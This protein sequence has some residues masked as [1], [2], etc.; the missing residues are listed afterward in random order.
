VAGFELGPERC[1]LL[2]PQIEWL[3][4]EAENLAALD[5]SSAEPIGVFRPA[6][7]PRTGSGEDK[8][9]PGRLADGGQVKG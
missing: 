7:S 4:G 1:K 5:L 8:A 6:P 3:L 9:A 2:A